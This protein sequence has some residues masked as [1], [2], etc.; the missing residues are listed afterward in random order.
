MTLLLG[1]IPV[2]FIAILMRLLWAVLDC[3]VNAR[4]LRN[5][6]LATPASPGTGIPNLFAA[7]SSISGRTSSVSFTCW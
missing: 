1:V 6:P 4:S 7:N 3:L 2:F 5:H